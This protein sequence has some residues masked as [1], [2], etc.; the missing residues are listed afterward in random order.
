M[1]NWVSGHDGVHG[2][3]R[4]DEEARKVASKGSS[5]EAELPELLQ[6]RTLPCSLAALGGK[7]KETLKHR[8]KAMWAKSPWKGWMDKIDDKLPSHSFLMAT[9]QLTRAQASILMQ[10][11]TGH[12]PLNYF[13]HKIG[14]VDSP[15]C[16][17]CWTTD[18]TVHHYLL[19]CPGMAH[20]RHSLAQ[21]MGRNS[22]SMRH[23]LGNWHAYK[24]LLKYV[25]TTGRF[26]QGY[27]W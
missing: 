24:P 2:N 15:T 18:E 27:I 11:R 26:T 4:A 21:A 13:L 16:P 23:L 10:L 19:D 20:E 9:S 6:E 22:K 1:F 5:L 12:I 25:R 14:K 3:E 7:F 17:M 8:W